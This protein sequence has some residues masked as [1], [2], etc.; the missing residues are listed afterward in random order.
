M[1]AGLLL[2]RKRV[3]PLVVGHWLLDLLGLG[4]PLLLAALA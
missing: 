2:W 4:L 3:V 1:F